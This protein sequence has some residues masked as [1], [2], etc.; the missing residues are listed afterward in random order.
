MRPSL[1]EQQA[2]SVPQHLPQKHLPPVTTDTTPRSGRISRPGARPTEASSLP[3][4]ASLDTGWV[5]TRCRAGESGTLVRPGRLW[6]GAAAQLS[7]PS[8]EV[9]IHKPQRV[10]GKPDA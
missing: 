7:S 4:T 9:S 2:W 5:K 1:R 6:D 8:A 3:S 10:A